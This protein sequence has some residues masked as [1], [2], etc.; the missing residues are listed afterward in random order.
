MCLCGLFLIVE[1]SLPWQI[2]LGAPLTPLLPSNVHHDRR[3][4][5]APTLNEDPMEAPQQEPESFTKDVGSQTKYRESEA[6]TAPYSRDFI[7]DP[8][9]EEPEVLM[10][11]GLVHG[12]LVGG[13]GRCDIGWSIVVTVI[14]DRYPQGTGTNRHRCSRRE[15]EMSGSAKS[16]SDKEQ[17][18]LQ[19][20]CQNAAIGTVAVIFVF[21][22]AQ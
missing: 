4:L 14:V 2:S 20:V 21:T 22:Q 10:L 12:E 19:G 8:E 9:S 13:R 1:A 16:H 3:R 5:L 6:Q 17:S 11:Q 18:S 7:L 15:C